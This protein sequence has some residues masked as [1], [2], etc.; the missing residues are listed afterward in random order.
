MKKWRGMIVSTGTLLA[1]CLG[2]WAMGEPVT[3]YSSYVNLLPGGKDKQSSNFDL[4][5]SAQEE[6]RALESEK[7]KRE[8][9]FDRP[10]D[11]HFLSDTYTMISFDVFF[12]PME[13][14]R[15]STNPAVFALLFK[16]TGRNGLSSYTSRYIKWIGKPDIQEYQDSQINDFCDYFRRAGVEDCFPGKGGEKAPEDTKKTKT[17]VVVQAM[18][19][20]MISSGIIKS[21]YIDPA[22]ARKKDVESGLEKNA[23]II[24]NLSDEIKQIRK[25]SDIIDSQ[26]KG[27]DQKIKHVSTLLLQTPPAKTRDD[28]SPTTDHLKEIEDTLK[29]QVSEIRDL[30]QQITALQELLQG[31][32]RNRNTLLLTGANLQIVNGTGESQGHS[33]G[34]GNLIIGYNEKKPGEP[35][36]PGSH[37]LILPKGESVVAPKDNEKK[38]EKKLFGGRCFIGTLWD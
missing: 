7:R 2:T 11:I 32:T 14:S 23:A 21:A 16:G 35:L 3:G 25:Q 27:M 36:Q 22:I 33:N 20:D 38:S 15:F 30:R 13:N 31:F 12:R 6:V 18:N 8:I 17:P 5:T 34:T 4:I 29:L 19:G 9:K 1:L 28:G 24:D 26:I 10:V 37:Q